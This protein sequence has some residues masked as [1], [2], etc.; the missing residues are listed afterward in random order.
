MLVLKHGVGI[1]VGSTSV[2]IV[3][4][5]GR[6]I[7]WAEATPH[8]GDVLG[9]VRRI[10]DSRSLPAGIPGMVTGGEGRRLV[11]LPGVIESLCVEQAV[12]DVDPPVAAVVSL[13]GE[14]L[15]VYQV[16][17]EGAVAGSFSGNK[18]AAG[19]G[20]FFEQQLGR[21]DMTVDDLAGVSADARV[22][23]LSSRCSVFMKSDCTH[24][25]NKGEA[26]R[27]DI[28]LS[29]AQVMALKVARALKVVKGANRFVATESRKRASSATTAITTTRT[30]VPTILTTTELA[31]T[32]PVV[33]ATSGALTAA[34]S[35]FIGRIQY[36]IDVYFC[37]MSFPGG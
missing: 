32:P 12:R 15:I 30:L 7:V 11:A 13:G 17:E 27:D 24:R 4:V 33:M 14:N 8:E 16:D 9:A 5:E 2:K 23:E 21:M 10:L 36:L 35:I 31:K 37:V 1:D 6:S 25:L 22:L 19:T 3:E 28:V 26:C 34:L 18:C 29:L 20:A